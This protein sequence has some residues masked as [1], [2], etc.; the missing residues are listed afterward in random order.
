VKRAAAFLLFFLPLWWLWQLLTGEW[1]RYEWVAGAIAAVIAAAIAVLAVTRTSGTAPFPLEVIRGAPSAFGMV[2]VD[3]CIV[4][5]ALVQRRR[6]VVRRTTF[7]H[8]DTEA[9]R[10]WAAIV[11]DWSPNAY[12]IDIAD[13]SSVTHHIVPRDPSQ[14]PA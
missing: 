12:V 4:M 3:F 5:V 13:G 14:R 2:F 6:G 8:P 7:P 9:Y 1:S 10:T 11:G